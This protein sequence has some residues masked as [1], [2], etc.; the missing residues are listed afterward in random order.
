MKIFLRTVRIPSTRYRLG[1]WSAFDILVQPIEIRIFPASRSRD[2][3]ISERCPAE[4]GEQHLQ[5]PRILHLRRFAE[6]P[7]TEA[8]VGEAAST[9]VGHEARK[10]ASPT[11]QI[12]GTL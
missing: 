10:D 7:A 12:E 8:A 2:T 6:C 1:V 11:D 3:R 4:A 5:Y 9:A